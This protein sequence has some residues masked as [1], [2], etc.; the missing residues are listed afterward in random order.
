MEKKSI[1]AGICI[2]ALSLSVLCVTFTNL[3]KNNPSL[4]HLDAQEDLYTLSL[5][6]THPHSGATK[7]DFFS[8]VFIF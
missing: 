3:N 1:L 2:G 5:D 7:I 6:G 8:I 4:F